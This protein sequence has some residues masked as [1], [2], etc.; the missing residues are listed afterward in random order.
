[1]EGIERSRV[2]V[3]VD[4]SLAG[5]RA[6]RVAVAEARRRGAA[7]HALRAWPYE[8]SVGLV[9]DMWARAAREAAADAI[10]GVFAEAMGGV[11]DDI[12]VRGVVVNGS[13]G[14]ALVGYADR[15]DDLLVVGCGQHGRLGRLLR[16]RVGRYC[17]VHASC[18]VLMVPPDAFAREAAR[19]RISRDLVQELEHGTAAA[20]P[21]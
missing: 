13:P 16:R 12:V 19:R 3:G 14:L 4:G 18:P 7:L 17:A 10:V 1:M 6:L 2:I 15:D 21:A 5:L 9:G 11:P 8:S 20:R